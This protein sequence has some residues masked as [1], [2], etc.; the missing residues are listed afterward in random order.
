MR[1]R[2]LFVSASVV[3]LLSAALTYAPGAAASACPA[4]GSS[5]GNLVIGAGTTCTLDNVRVSG[6]VS[7]GAHAVLSTKNGTKI[8]GSLSGTNVR[9]LTLLGGS[10]GDSLSISGTDGSGNTS[11]VCGVTIKL[12][13][14]ITQIG[15][16]DEVDFGDDPPAT[17]VGNTVGGSVNASNNG[18]FTPNVETEL[19]VDSNHIGG[20]LAMNN[21]NNTVMDAAGNTIQGSFTCS[22]GRDSDGHPNVPKNDEV[23]NSVGGTRTCFPTPNP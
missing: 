11:K 15:N 18:S 22:G 21:N 3:A 8:Q 12:N 1:Y 19:E 14:L 10:I 5:V 23:P 6:N 2:R 16:E 13:V 7:V 9:R 17:C 20:S 4:P